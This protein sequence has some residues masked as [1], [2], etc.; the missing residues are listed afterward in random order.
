MRPGRLGC[1]LRCLGMGRHQQGELKS[2]L[3]QLQSLVNTELVAP[4]KG[5]VERTALIANVS[6]VRRPQRLALCCELSVVHSSCVT[7][8]G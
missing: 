7:V 2:Y 5:S 8:D 6:S 3:L 4:L 1:L